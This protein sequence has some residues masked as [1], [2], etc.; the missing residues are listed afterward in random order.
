M[1]DAHWEPEINVKGLGR[2]SAL[3][4]AGQDGKKLE[5]KIKEK[6]HE[7]IGWVVAKHGCK[8]KVCNP[9]SKEKL[10]AMFSDC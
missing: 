5:T 1:R 6:K 8:L 4:L 2:G 9:K 3:R 10:L 7:M